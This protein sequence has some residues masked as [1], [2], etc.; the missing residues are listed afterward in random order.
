[1]LAPTQRPL[2][3]NGPSLPSFRKTE[4]PRPGLGLHPDAVGL[5]ADA[6]PPD[7]VNILVVDDEPGNLLALEVT[8]AGLGVTVRTAR[9]GLE[10]LK[11]LL[12][13]DFA[14]ILMDV[15]MPGMDGFETA[16]LIRQRKRSQYTPII[17]LTAYETTELQVFKGYSLGAVDY[18]SKP[19]IPEVLRSKVAAFVEMFRKAEQIKQQAELLRQIERREHQRQLA[20]AKARWEAERLQDEIRIAR[21]IQQ[22]LFPAAPL[23]LP[24]FDISGASYPAEAT[25]G[26]YFD[27]IPM[28]DGALGLVIGDVAGHGFGPA[29]LMAETR[30][31]LRAFLMTHTDVGE[32]VGLVNR[33][34]VNDTPDDRFATLVLARLDP[35]DHSLT[36]TSAGHVTGYVL[37]PAGGVRQPLESTGMPLGIHAEA[38]FPAAAPLQ[39]RPGEVILFMTDGMFEAHS[40]DETPFG[41]ARVLETVRA[42]RGRSAR[43]IVDTLYSTVR[44]FCGVKAS[45]D[46]MTAIVIKVGPAA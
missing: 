26:D 46:D 2:P 36:Y 19:F 15:K 23:P 43:E 8:L 31:Y 6:V 30:A 32:I 9:S 5:D 40:T 34:L 42:H 22:K 7:K 44:A 38:E 4:Q 27:Y 24:G 33:A 10:A 39:L 11:S 37:D 25:G 41:T 1:M 3:G 28:C 13:E 29:L 20:E 14:V 21:Q 17:F 16:A 35:R 45:L 12:Q 18:L